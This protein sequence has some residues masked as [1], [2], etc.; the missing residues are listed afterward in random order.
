MK[1]INLNKILHKEL[2]SSKTGEIY[3]KSAVLTDFFD[4]HDMFVHHEILQSG[5]RSSVPHYHTLQEEMVIILYGSPTCYL[6]KEKIQMQP[7]DV[8]GFKPNLAESHYIEN[9]S[10]EIVHM[11]V[12]CSNPKNDIVL[13]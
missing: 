11:L 13:V 7:G 12:I 10:E 8:V 9:L 1:I 3:S 2:I 5:R 4:F 6:G